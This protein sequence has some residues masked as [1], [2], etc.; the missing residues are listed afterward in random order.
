MIIPGKYIKAV[1]LFAPKND[2]R[3][4]LNGVCFEVSDSKVILTATTGYSMCSA[5]VDVE[6][7]Q[8]PGKYIV[9]LEYLSDADPKSNVDITFDNN[10][11]T[12]TKNNRSVTAAL[13]DGNFPDWRRV[14]PDKVSG[15]VAQLCPENIVTAL[16]AKRILLDDNKIQGLYISHN[17]ADPAVIVI[18]VPEVIILISP[19]RT[20]TFSYNKPEWI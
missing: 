12:L 9:G 11:V 17:G 15:E 13:I 10:N 19:F 20:E 18:G 1:S 5:P 16:K 6:S 7:G 2:V 14:V 8:L 4:Y 3:S